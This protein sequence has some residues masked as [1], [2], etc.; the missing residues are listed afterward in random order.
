MIID[1][2]YTRALCSLYATTIIRTLGIIGA[3]ISGVFAL[4]ALV[5]SLFQVSGNIS[6]T[7][8]D[9]QRDMTVVVMDNPML[10]GGLVPTAGY[11]NMLSVDRTI[12]IS[13]SSL[14]LFSETDFSLLLDHEQFH[15]EQKEFVAERSEGF[16]AIDKPLQTL[17]YFFAFVQFEL[18]LR[19][20]MPE[21]RDGRGEIVRGLEASADCFAQPSNQ[22]LQYAGFYLQYETI[23]TA[24]QVWIVESVLDGRYPV[25]ITDEE[26]A[27]LAP[28]VVFPVPAEIYTTAP[29]VITYPNSTKIAFSDVL[30]SLETKSLVEGFHKV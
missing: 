15:L 19:E 26:R 18:D 22:H 14:V 27:E 17:R 20:V 3:V 13:E 2:A 6:E 11:V 4:N 9:E 5:F 1:F 25:A 23:C 12:Y 29:Y 28:V 10:A 24:E 21:V 16:P 30:E 7:F 8:Y